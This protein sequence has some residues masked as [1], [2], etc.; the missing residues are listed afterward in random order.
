MLPPQVTLQHSFGG[1]LE[2]EVGWWCKTGAEARGNGGGVLKRDK[3]NI[4]D[5][6]PVV[7]GKLGSLRHPDL[8]GNLPNEPQSSCLHSKISHPL[9]TRTKWDVI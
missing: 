5:Y 1:H 7:V 6:L 2:V 4:L 8:V 3:I 9:L